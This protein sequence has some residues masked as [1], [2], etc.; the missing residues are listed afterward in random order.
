M[1]R[2]AAE[3]LQNDINPENLLVGQFVGK[4]KIIQ[5]FWCAVP[6]RG[7]RID[8]AGSS[9]SIRDRVKPNASNDSTSRA[10][11]LHDVLAALS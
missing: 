2:A 10:D 11:K 9:C 5:H 6:L 4:E 7:S 1:V 3:I 8:Q